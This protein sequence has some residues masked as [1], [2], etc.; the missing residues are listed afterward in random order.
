MDQNNQVKWREFG[1]HLYNEFERLGLCKEKVADELGLA[2]ARSIY[3]W[4][5]GE[6]LPKCEHL[7]LLHQKF[8][9]SFYGV[10]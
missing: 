1:D 3:K 7:I 8:N 2:T 9:I 6:C 4:L 10:L 5:N